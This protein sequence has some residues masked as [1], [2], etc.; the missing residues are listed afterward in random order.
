MSEC[1]N[2]LY[3]KIDIKWS[4]RDD[5]EKRIMGDCYFNPPVLCQTLIPAV[6]RA[7]GYIALRDKQPMFQMRPLTESDSFCS[8]FVKKK[9]KKEVKKRPM[10]L[11]RKK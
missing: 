3:W 10:K 1:K 2:C 5:K 4:P 6:I 9:K 7:S 8:N 11:K